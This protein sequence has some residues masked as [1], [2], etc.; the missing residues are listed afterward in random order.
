MPIHLCKGRLQLR[1]GT[2]RRVVFRKLGTRNHL[3]KSAAYGFWHMRVC[4]NR[5]ALGV[6]VGERVCDVGV[7]KAREVWVCNRMMPCGVGD[8][9]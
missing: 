9:A 1:N 8:M 3:G 5:A 4:R 7:R 6:W 2:Q